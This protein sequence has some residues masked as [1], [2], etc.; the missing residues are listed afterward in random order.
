MKDA[1]NFI[2]TKSIVCKPIVTLPISFREEADSSI[3]PFLW[4]K[5]LDLWMFL[6]FLLLDQIDKNNRATLYM[7]IEKVQHKCLAGGQAGVTNNK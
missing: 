2:G 4:C 5:L 6:V 7:K 1:L 3:F